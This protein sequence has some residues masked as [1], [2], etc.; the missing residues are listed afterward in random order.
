MNKRPLIG[1]IIVVL[2]VALAIGA[3]FFYGKKATPKVYQVG[4]VSGAPTFDNI[5]GSFKA[6]MANLGYIEGTNIAYDFQKTNGDPSLITAV[7]KKF[8]DEKVDL[9]FA[10]PTE[11][12]VAAKAAV[13]GTDIPVVFAMAGVEGDNLVESVSS[14]GGNIT[15]V[16][17]PGPQLTPKRFEFLLELVPKAK[18]VYLAYDKNYPNAPM[19]L[20]ELRPAAAA[21]GVTLVED[22]VNN[23]EELRAALQKRAA[24]TSIGIDAILLMPDILD[25]SPDGFEAILQFANE[26]KIPIGGGMDFTADLGALFSYV[27]DNVQQG[28]LAAA[29]AV[30]I[31]TGTPAGTIPLD[32]PNA[33]L[34]LNYKAIQALGLTAPEDLLS[35]ASEIIR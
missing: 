2:A 13:Q 4:M 16:R 1:G 5:G 33:S 35:Q 25:N 24:A 7:I 10:F 34:R 12:A 32:T 9:I 27:P 18:R 29:I 11:P 21:A 17:F 14:P 15:G 22:P 6:E 30:K 3:Y 23:V 20:G 26:H 31:F 8:V 28:K 19:A